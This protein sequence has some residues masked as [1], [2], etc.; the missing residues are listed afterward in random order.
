MSTLS[1]Q[2][3]ALKGPALDPT[4]LSA[5]IHAHLAAA[6]AH[7]V[8]SPLVD[9]HTA[10]AIHA[11]CAQLLADWP[12]L[13]PEQRLWTQAACLYFADPDEVQ[14]EPDFDSIV[15]FDDDLDALNLCLER[16]GRPTVHP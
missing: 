16:I 4:D 5:R 12:H 9:L 1:K 6:T 13:D 15:G 8:T 10:T 3:L 2:L 14:G 7:A 11:A